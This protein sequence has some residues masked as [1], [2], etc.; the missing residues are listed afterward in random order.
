MKG[1]I[2]ENIKNFLNNI[3]NQFIEYEPTVFLIDKKDY[4]NL[5]SIIKKNYSPYIFVGYGSRS[6]FKVPADEEYINLQF[7][8]FDTY[9]DIPYIYR[10]IIETLV[11]NNIKVNLNEFLNNFYKLKKLT[12]KIY[13]YDEAKK[14]RE[15]AEELLKLYF[16]ILYKL[17]NYI[18]NYTIKKER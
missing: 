15:Q 13:N 6:F 2:M 10:N 14:H 5:E 9:A 4:N 18:F 8:K 16:N 12:N 7:K 1:K 11:K 17:N 3:D